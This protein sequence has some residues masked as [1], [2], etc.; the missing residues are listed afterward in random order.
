MGHLDR[1]LSR[2]AE[3]ANLRVAA[4]TRAGAHWHDVVLTR[5]E[6]RHIDVLA[7]EEAALRETLSRADAAIADALRAL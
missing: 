1:P 3:A 4:Q 2:L 7:V 5:L 6:D